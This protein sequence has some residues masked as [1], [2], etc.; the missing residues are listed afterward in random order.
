MAFTE[1]AVC[2]DPT[3]VSVGTDRA[4]KVWDEPPP[5]LV[6]AVVAFRLVFPTEG[7]LD[8]RHESEPSFRLASLEL[9]GGRHAQ[10]VAHADPK[11]A[12]SKSFAAARV[13]VPTQAE[14]AGIAVPD[15]GY[16]YLFGKHSDGARFIVGAWAKVAH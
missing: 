8:V 1:E 3:L 2:K 15:S 4:W 11:G 5:Q 10:L 12:N 13:D 7:D 6:D 9:R 16:L 14:Q